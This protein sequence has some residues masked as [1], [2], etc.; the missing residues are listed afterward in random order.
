MGF[1]NLNSNYPKCHTSSST[2]KESA[3][4]FRKNHFLPTDRLFA[5]LRISPMRRAL[6]R[7]LQNQI[8]L[9]LGP[10]PLHGLRPTRLSRKPPR[11]SS[12]PTKQSTK[13][14]SPR[15]RKPERKPRT[16]WPTWR[17]IRNGCAM[18]ISEPRVCSSALGWWRRDVRPLLVSG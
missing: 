5:N 16:R 12:V 17:R 15:S 14:L 10:V 18:R 6:P 1:I 7:Q 3:H 9:L 4:E 8:L 2:R 13:T 11:Y